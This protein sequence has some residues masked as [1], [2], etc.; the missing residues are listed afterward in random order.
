MQHT[1]RRRLTHALLATLLLCAPVIAAHAASA[2]TLYVA[3]YN[4]RGDFSSDRKS[5]NG[6]AQRCPVIVSL[7]RFH[8]FDFVGSQEVLPR[9]LENMLKQMPEY[10]CI[11]GGG[12]MD[13]KSGGE[14]NA[15]FY[16]KE[17]FA[18]L[19]RGMFWLSETPD[20]PGS[21]GWDAMFSRI[22][23]WGKF[24]IKGS[25]GKKTIHVFNL[26]M[27]H[28]GAKSREE[29]A[30][31]VLAKMRKIAGDGPAV[32]LGDFNVSHRAAPYAVL[33]G[34]GYLADCFEAAPIKYHSNG[35]FNRFDLTRKTD[36]RIDHIFI[37][38][39]L[40]AERYAILGDCYWIPQPGEAAAPGKGLARLPSDHFPVAAK[41]RFAK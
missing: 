5:H 41:L 4:V 23:S 26:H 27:D 30:K 3:T 1:A 22:C 38:K 40:T 31:L 7:I 11:P 32:L 12:P 25:D 13:G 35:T 33:A 29:S 8:D 14:Y 16:N 19:E 34:S 36:E 21:K 37:T 28:R 10:D 20:V 15:L 24:E 2:G 17:R 39:Q 18:L 6:W 9:Q